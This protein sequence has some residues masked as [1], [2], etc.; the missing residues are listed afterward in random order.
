MTLDNNVWD[1]LFE[2]NI[3]LAAE[4]PATGFV[5][6]V[7]REVEIESVAI[8]NSQ[9]KISL[10]EYIDQTISRCCIRT[11]TVFGYGM[12]DA[13]PQRLGGFNC[14]T[15]QSQTEREF[16]A[17]ISK[18]YLIDRAKKKNQLTHNEAD[19]AIAAQSFYSIALT[20]EKPKKTG[21]L[22]FAAEHGGKVVY[23]PGIEQS[24]VTL[25]EYISAFHRA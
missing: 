25:S 15:W 12:D 13:S 22:R 24:G 9:D 5:I 19:A 23:L 7:T 16:Y 14:G 8:A 3:D 4:L 11:T 20:C 1:F 6:F 2:K 21:P 10:K 18:Q 17:E